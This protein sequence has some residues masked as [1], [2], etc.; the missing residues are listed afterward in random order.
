VSA[1]RQFAD[2]RLG[3]ALALFSIAPEVIVRLTR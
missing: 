1:R 2:A 3:A